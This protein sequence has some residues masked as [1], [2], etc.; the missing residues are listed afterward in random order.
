MIL[1]DVF[2]CP[3]LSNW[4]EQRKI[5]KRKYRRTDTAAPSRS[6]A[7]D[8]PSPS[9]CEVVADLVDLS[10]TAVRFPFFL[11]LFA[12]Q[13]SS[14]KSRSPWSF[15]SRSPFRLLPSPI[16]TP[17]KSPSINLFVAAPSTAKSP[18]LLRRRFRAATVDRLCP[19]LNRRLVFQARHD[20]A[21]GEVVAIANAAS[22]RFPLAG[23][24]AT[25]METNG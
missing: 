12:Y 1:E 2:A 8:A 21:L 11:L 5:K 17:R 7:V 25:Y 22:H 9:V 16:R 19:F 3:Y 15:L 20:S 10:S 6:S 23:S 24:V 13:G 4:E 14:S 18:L